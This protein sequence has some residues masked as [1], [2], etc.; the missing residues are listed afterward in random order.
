MRNLTF[1]HEPICGN[2]FVPAQ[3]DVEECINDCLDKSLSQEFA[4]E[5][6]P[7]STMTINKMGS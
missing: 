1:S 5:E 6:K 4:H 2:D 7:F 3:V